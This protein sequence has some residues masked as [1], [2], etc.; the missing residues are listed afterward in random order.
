MDRG[1]ILRVIIGAKFGRDGEVVTVLTGEDI[2]AWSRPFIAGVKQ[3]MR[4]Y[5]LA[6]DRVRYT[7][8]PVAVVVA[9]D[10]YGAED[11][12]ERIEVEYR[13]LDPVVDPVAAAAPGA[14]LLH[15]DVGSNVVSDRRLRYGDPDAAFAS[16]AHRLAISVRYPRNACT[17]IEGFVVVAEHLGDDGYDVL[18]NFQGP[19]TLHPVMARALG[20]PGARLRLRSPRDSGGSFGVKQA[21]FPYVVAM[22]LASRKA[23]C[24]VK[25]VEDRLEHLLAAT[26]ATNRVTTL[27]AAV[28]GDGTIAALRWD[29]LD[30]CGAYL[31]APEPASLYR[32]HG[33]MTGPYRI[34]HLEVHNRV[35]LTNKT[36]TGLNRG[37]GG[38]QVY[39]A[40]ERLVHRIAKTLGLDPLDVIRRNLV[41]GTAFRVFQQCQSISAVNAGLTMP[42]RWS[43]TSASTRRPASCVSAS[44]TTTPRRRWTRR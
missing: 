41:P 34:A 17:P 38:P 31:R 2:V 37:F 22:C 28:T 10:R 6:V 9:R 21:V 3:P 18:S 43:D 26:S 29:Q 4:H 23:R 14:P 36:P 16:A 5:A 19:F 8:E 32:T 40:L 33:H 44:P 42:T 24:P 15:R 7:G 39:F 20:V 25:W 12:L 11:A 35:V 27:E 13:E 1:G 30:D